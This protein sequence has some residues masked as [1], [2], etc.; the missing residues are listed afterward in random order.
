MSGTWKDRKSRCDDHSPDTRASILPDKDQDAPIVTLVGT[1]RKL[2]PGDPLVGHLIRPEECSVAEAEPKYRGCQ[3]RWEARM[4]MTGSGASSGDADTP[5]PLNALGPNVMVSSAGRRV[6]LVRAFQEAV[7]P[8][9]GRVIATDRRPNLS[10]ACQVA[11]ANAEVSAIGDPSYVEQTLALAEQHSVGLVV[12]TLD[13]ELLPLARARESMASRGVHVSVPD[14][15]LVVQCRDKRRTA[16]LFE[17]LGIPPLREVTDEYPRFVKPLHGSL[18][19]DSHSIPTAAELTPRLADHQ[20]FI[21]QEL[22]DPSVYTEF[23]VDALYDRDGHLICAVPRR[24]IEVRGGE[25]SKGRTEKGPVL[26]AVRDRLSTVEGARGCLCMQFFHS[27]VRPE[28]SLIGIEINARFGGGY[29]MSDAAGATMARWLVEEIIWNRPS[30]YR[31]DWRDGLTFL[32]Y[33][34]QVIVGG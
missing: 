10:A 28:R 34:D 8:Y 7:R 31:E 32:R 18:S 5:R 20:V 21:H 22:I 6:G 13:T 23:T 24:R 30:G 33:D 3:G 17:S 9:G 11:D 2:G 16:A 27:P 15:E 4:P 25:I 1:A 19:A 14:T 12:P 29:P 26:D